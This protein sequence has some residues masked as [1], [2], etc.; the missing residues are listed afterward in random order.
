[1]NLYSSWFTQT[2]LR[3]IFCC[4]CEQRR[5]ACST[6]LESVAVVPVF[7]AEE[8]VA[9]GVEALQPVSA[10]DELLELER[11][12]LVPGGV[13]RHGAGAHRRPRHVDAAFLA[14]ERRRLQRR[15]LDQEVAKRSRH[16]P[17]R[18][19]AE[20]PV[21]APQEHLRACCATTRSIH[22]DAR[23]A[24]TNGQCYVLLTRTNKRIHQPCVKIK[25]G[26][27]GSGDASMGLK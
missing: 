8:A 1:M 14:R 13:G 12:A 3:W 7:G 22:S 16:A 26:S 21:P 9:D 24:R 20:A 15:R 27:P 5:E 25:V 23:A 17:E 18:R 6:L 2:L 11:Q 19:L 4:P 10:L